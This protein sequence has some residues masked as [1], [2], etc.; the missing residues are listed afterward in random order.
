MLHYKTTLKPD[1]QTDMFLEL[2]LPRRYTKKRIPQLL[3]E[4]FFPSKKQLCIWIIN[5][6]INVPVPS[7]KYAHRIM[8]LE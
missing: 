5:S 2:E 4:Y 3:G 7:E 1:L 6:Y 8:E